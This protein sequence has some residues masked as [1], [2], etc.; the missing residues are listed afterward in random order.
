[1]LAAR[2][3]PPAV[4]VMKMRAMCLSFRLTLASSAYGATRA[5]SSVVNIGG[6]EVP[7][8]LSRAQS[9]ASV[10]GSSAAQLA[11]PE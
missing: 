11:T 9:E 3:S 7:A 1:M 8:R 10:T 5:P 6:G 4:P 2:P